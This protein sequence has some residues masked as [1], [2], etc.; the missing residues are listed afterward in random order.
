MHLQKGLHS[1]SELN[2]KD[3]LSPV[4]VCFP[5]KGNRGYLQ[6]HKNVEAGRDLWRSSGSN[7]PS[8]GGP[9]RAGCPT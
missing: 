1:H 7:I 3:L 9:S 8:R 2:Q 6:N 4:L 5:D